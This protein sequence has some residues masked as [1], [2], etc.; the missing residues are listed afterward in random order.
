MARLLRAVLCDAWIQTSGKDNLIGVFERW[1]VQKLPHVCSDFCLNAKVEATQGPH[2]FSI[3]IADERDNPCGPPKKILFMIENPNAG[4]TINYFYQ[5]F[6]LT[7]A[8]LTRF[9]CSIDGE[10]IGEA[11]FDV[12]VLKPPALESVPDKENP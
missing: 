10:F 9:M 8:G 5:Q 6:V 11:V 2:V 4:L 1:T 7:R 12:V 3:Q